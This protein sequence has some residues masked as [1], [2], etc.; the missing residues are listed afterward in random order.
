[1]PATAVDV[2][3]R[4]R[5][6]PWIVGLVAALL[7]PLLYGSALHQRLG[8][9]AA[10]T[11]GAL[12]AFVSRE[13]LAEPVLW[14]F[15][16]SKLLASF[17]RDSGAPIARARI[18]ACDG[19]LLAT[20]PRDSA[21]GPIVWRAV[22]VGR[23]P[24]AWV[25]VA[26][27]AA[28]GHRRLGWLTLLSCLVGLLLGVWLHRRPLA[29]LRHAAAHQRALLGALDVA[30]DAL[31]LSNHELTQKVEVA[32]AK[33]RALTERVIAVQEAERQRIA[34]DL[35]DEVGQQLAAL[36]LSLDSAAQHA[37]PHALDH[38]TACC[39]ATLEGLRRA[40]HDLRPLELDQRTLGAALRALTERVE[41]ASGLPIA[42]RLEGD[43]LPASSV[44]TALLR[45]CQEALNNA[46]RHAAATEIAIGLRVGADTVYVSIRDDGIGAT[47]DTLAAG[48]GVAGMAE[49]ARFLGGTFEIGPSVTEEIKSQAVAT[50]SATAACAPARLGVWVQVKL[51][52]AVVKVERAD[53]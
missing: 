49:R 15:G 51:P 34:M 13:S 35:H 22:T 33:N 17:A 47:S 10:R 2:A 37:A 45:I 53:G 4:T 24:V 50:A 42:L 40:V 21:A 25:A 23:T 20:F 7:P 52:R 28:P 31:Q 41:L 14:R 44:A 16:A 39:V 30:R 43:Q 8:S 5:R 38:A 29:A 12:A 48:G 32:D 36:R 18:I 3:V 1:M 26:V 27:D 6:L 11:A 9:D 46:V 19:G